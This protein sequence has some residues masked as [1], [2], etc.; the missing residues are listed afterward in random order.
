MAASSGELLKSP[1]FAMADPL[2]VGLENDV[3]E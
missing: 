1:R 3:S 2:V